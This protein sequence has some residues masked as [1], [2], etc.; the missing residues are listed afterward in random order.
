MSYE[1]TGCGASLLATDSWDVVRL[2]GAQEEGTW[3]HDR[4]LGSPTREV[5]QDVRI[6]DR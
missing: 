6:R 1:E 2:L 4:R 3:S 5:G